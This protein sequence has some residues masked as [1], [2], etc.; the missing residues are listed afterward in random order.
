VADR[1]PGVARRREPAIYWDWNATTPPHPDVLAA[2]ADAH[3]NA[4][5][6][7]SSQHRHGRTARALIEDVRELIGARLGFHPRDVLFVGSGTEANNLALSRA[8]ALVASRLDH[9]SVVRCAECLEAR[10]TPVSWL[11]VPANGRLSQLDIERAVAALQR[12]D[13]GPI[14]VALTAANHET[15]VLQD[16]P[17]L[18]VVARRLGAELH[19]DA[20]QALGKIPFE[21]LAGADSVT[22]VAHKVRG[23]QGVAALGWRG[24]PPSPILL[25]GS[26]ER[27]LRPGTQSAALVAG[28]G[29][30]LRR[31][32]PA[33]YATLAPLR[34]E[35]ER[36]LGPW[37]VVNGAGA[38]RLPHVSSLSFAGWSGE[39]LVAALDVRGLSISTGSACR[40][41]TAEPSAV[42]SAMLGAQRAGSAV[43]VSLGE[44]ATADELQRGIALWVPLVANKIEG[45]S[46]TA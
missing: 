29:A 20:A 7:P 2:M 41:G 33:R 3:A 44:D 16:V 46:S 37:A 25:G 24:S 31:L 8:S 32:D 9:P 12:P 11:R 21:A 18:S 45:T 14:V 26:Q 30:A 43:R 40:V 15:G 28:F 6:N 35:L 10:G 13:R 4:W 5:A 1:E 27:G 39:R 19:V 22:L 17:A 23:P 38:P 34:D 36:A 42:V